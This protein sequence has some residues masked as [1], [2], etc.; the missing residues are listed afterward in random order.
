M[1]AQVVEEDAIFIAL[2]LLVMGV[3]I[4]PW[5]RRKEARLGEV[6]HPRKKPQ[7]RVTLDPR[8]ADRQEA[9]SP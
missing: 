1:A 2:F 4:A 7:L 5:G 3:H 9:S 6:G 8:Q